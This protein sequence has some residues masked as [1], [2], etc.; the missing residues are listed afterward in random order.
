MPLVTPLSTGCRGKCVIGSPRTHSSA[1]ASN[2]CDSRQNKTH[3][4]SKREQIPSSAYHKS[5]ALMQPVFRATSTSCHAGRGLAGPG[6]PI[7][8]IADKIKHIHFQ[9]ESKY[10]LL[11]TIRVLLLCSQSLELLQPLATQAEAWQAIP[12]VSE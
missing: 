1:R 12:G 6:H 5:P 4:F 10:P 8:V 7:A 2:R 11:P 3:T 9:K